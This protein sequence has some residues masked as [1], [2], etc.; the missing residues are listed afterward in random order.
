MGRSVRLDLDLLAETPHRDP[1][2]GRVRVLGLRPAASEERL[3]CHRL[4]KVGRQ[5]VEEARLGRRQLDRLAPDGRLAA[6]E[7]E[8]QVRSEDEALARHLVAEPPE[9]PVDPGAQLGVVVGLR[10]VVLGDLLEQ[11]GLGVAGIDRGQDDDREVGPALDLAGEGQAVHPRHHHVDDQEVRPAAL[12]A[13][14]RLVAVARGLDVEAVGPELVGEQDQQVRVVVDDQD[15]RRRPLAP[16]S[17][18][19]HRRLSMAGA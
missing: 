1:D 7:V 16:G 18:A 6:V 13:A 17:T 3:G 19:Q 4:A 2:V 11:V 15:P 10:D 5:G 8:G 9:D 14:E 12:Q